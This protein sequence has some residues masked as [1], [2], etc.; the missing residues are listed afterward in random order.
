[1]IIL[2]NLLDAKDFKAAVDEIAAPFRAE[3]ELPPIHQLGLVVASVEAASEELE[4][5]GVGPFFI[6]EAAARRWRENGEERSFA[7]KLGTGYRDGLEFESLEPGEGSDFYRNDLDPQGRIVVQHLG[8]HVEDVDR[9]VE[10]LNRAGH[11]ERVRGQFKIGPLVADFAYMETVDA[12]GIIIELMS[13]K[14]LSFRVRPVPAL[15]HAVGRL[16]K[17][18]GKRSVSI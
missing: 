9:W 1:M 6:G 4:A 10:K 12:A 2:M 17:W 15:V 7:G 3:F 5:R 11:R 14:L 8:F 18:T 13:M 16:Q